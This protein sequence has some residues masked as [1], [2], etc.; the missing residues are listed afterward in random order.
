M[1]KSRKIAA[2]EPPVLFHP[3][4]RNPPDKAA[5]LDAL[6]AAF[7]AYR[8]SVNYCPQCFGEGE[9]ARFRSARPVERADP[10]V[11]ALIYGEHPDC[12]GGLEALRHWLPRAMEVAFFSAD[13]FPG[14]IAQCY[15]AGL[16]YWPGEEQKA[17]RDIVCR[18]AINWFS[19]QEPLPLS[20]PETMRCCPDGQVCRRKRVGISSQLVEALMLLRVDPDAIISY[21]ARE[22]GDRGRR[23]L[24]ET[25][26]HFEIGDD[27]VYYYLPSEPLAE[28]PLKS[29]LAAIRRL[30]NHALSVACAPETLLQW[31][32]QAISDAPDLAERIAEV[33]Y[34]P[35]TYEPWASAEQCR[36]DRAV[37]MKALVI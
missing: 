9:V 22:G 18:A 35:R 36:S 10:A 16:W 23:F 5:R 1:A 37:I 17:L 32:E 27:I 33:E 30:A 29:A 21:L 3:F 7:S 28:E 15:R 14:L 6:Y 2:S 20:L 34:D 4:E 25:V 12:V 13:V 24:V 8:A 19:D 26:G 31:W 11:A